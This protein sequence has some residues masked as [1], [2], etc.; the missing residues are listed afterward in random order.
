MT[1]FP[2]I[3]SCYHQIIR[4]WDGFFDSDPDPRA[5]YI[6]Y[7]K[8]A[9]DDPANLFHPWDRAGFRHPPERLKESSPHWNFPSESWPNVPQHFK[10]DPRRA[11]IVTV[12]MNPKL[13][14]SLQSVR[15]DVADEINQ[16][17]RDI[18]LYEQAQILQSLRCPNAHWWNWFD[19]H[20]IRFDPAG[21]NFPLA[22]ADEW[23]KAW[24]KDFLYFELE[25]IPYQSYSFNEALMLAGGVDSLKSSQFSLTLLRALLNDSERHPRLFVIRGAETR[26]RLAKLFPDDLELANQRK[27]LYT[28][29]NDR[30]RT[31]R[32]TNLV[33][34]NPQTGD[35][36]SGPSL[37]E[38]WMD[39]DVDQRRRFTEPIAP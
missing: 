34:F 25:L 16:I 29:A 1:Q 35:K 9:R 6:K 28:F 5:S 22:G 31:L 10:G 26:R 7:A 17:D 2:S 13:D 11:R 38:V 19:K 37:A 8:D 15:K 4:F 20:Q 39:W 32:A 18:R 33:P 24:Q 23:R 12:L 30:N 3:E 27:L 21:A 36:I 14:S